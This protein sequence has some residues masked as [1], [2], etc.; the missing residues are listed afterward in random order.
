M[1]QSG[2]IPVQNPYN[3]LIKQVHVKKTAIIGIGIAIIVAGVIGIYAVSNIEE[4]PS[5]GDSAI[6]LSDDAGVTIQEPEDTE[7]KISVERD[8]TIKDEASATA[9]DPEDTEEGQGDPIGFQDSASVTV[10]NP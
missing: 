8:I 2:V 4:S 7:G 10:E 6:G 1:N 5:A 9:E 3:F